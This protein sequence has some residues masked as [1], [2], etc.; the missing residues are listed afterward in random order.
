MPQD[1]ERTRWLVVSARRVCIH[2]PT[3]L[4][5]LGFFDKLLA[6]DVWVVLDDAELSRQSWIT[7]V[8]VRNGGERLLLSIPVRHRFSD[9]APLHDIRIDT[10]HHWQRKHDRALRQ[11][12]GRSPHFA[13]IEPLL[14]VL[15]TTP[16]ERLVDFTM[17]GLEWLRERLGV[18]VEIV[19]SSRLDAGA[20][21]GTERLVRLTRAVGGEVYVTGSGSRGYLEP[22]QF[23]AAGLGLE[24]QDYVEQP[25]RQGRGAFVNRLSALDAMA[26]LGA[27]GSAELLRRGHRRPRAQE[28]QA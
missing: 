28:V 22:A 1:A 5:W 10:S 4:P 19:Y 6:S 15:Y 23:Y 14:V 12:Y 8:H 16:A 17:I 13:A 9:H 11:S 18:A 2:Q 7:R 24:W 25:Y 20:A 21:T 3:Y 27:A 26:E